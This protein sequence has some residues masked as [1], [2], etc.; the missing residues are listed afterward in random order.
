MS[1]V[2]AKIR[3]FDPAT[4]TWLIADRLGISPKYVANVQWRDRAAARRKALV[5]ARQEGKGLERVYRLG[6]PRRAAWL[7]HWTRLGGLDQAR[8]RD[9]EQ[10]RAP[11]TVTAGWPPESPEVEVVSFRDGI[12]QFVIPPGTPEFASHVALLRKLGRHAAAQ[13]MEMG[14]RPIKPFVRWGSGEG[15]R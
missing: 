7:A 4:P 8:A 3:K 13:G 12:T 5:A 14:G 10:R 2:S 6:D 1:T 9:L 15:G 11:I